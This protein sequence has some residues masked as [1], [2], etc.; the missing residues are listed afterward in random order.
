VDQCGISRLVDD[1]QRLLTSSVLSEKEMAFF[2][3]E[4]AQQKEAEQARREKLAEKKDTRTKKNV[5]P[6]HFFEIFSL[7]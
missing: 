1:L 6:S 2:A 3:A 5:K 7:R 4:F